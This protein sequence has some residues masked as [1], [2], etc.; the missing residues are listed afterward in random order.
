[1]ARRPSHWA[2]Y[3][4]DLETVKLLVHGGANVSTA[5]RYGV[6]ALSLACSNGNVAMVELLLEG[7]AD[8]NTTLRGGETALMT[9]ARTGKPGPVKALLSRGAEVDAKVGR[10]QTALMWA[11]AEGHVEVVEELLQAGA[12]FRTALPDSGFTPLLFAVREGRS[13]VVQTLLKAG[14]DVNGTVQPGPKPLAY[15]FHHYRGPTAGSSPLIL[16]VENGHFELAAALLEAGADPNDERSG[17]TALHTIT[18]VRKPG[19][20][21]SGDPAPQGS[22]N[23]SSL[24]FVRELVA[25]GADVNAKLEERLEKGMW[26]KGQIGRV[27]ATPFLLAAITA[28]VALMRTLVALGADPLLP[29]AENC[30]PLMAAA[31]VGTSSPGE[32]AGTEP[33]V[34]EAVQLLLDLGVDLNAVD[35]NGETAMHGVAYKNLPKVVQFLAD[36]GANIEVWNK[37]NKYGWTPLLLAEGHRFGNFKVAPED[38]SRGSSSDDRRGRLSADKSYAL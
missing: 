8:P 17:F 34:L 31:G 4:D 16:A 19:R 10:G 1:M 38:S 14:V 15:N 18:W 23:M 12:D 37:K 27:G 2:A 3:Q 21:D 13:R 9:A 20:G 33:E 36:K 24:Q 35:D 29:N 22:G 30:T 5:N 26:G 25:H 11:A 6:A 7:G 32:V 28:D